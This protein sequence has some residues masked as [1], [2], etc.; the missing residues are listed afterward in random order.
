MAQL[1]KAIIWQKV[2]ANKDWEDLTDDEKAVFIEQATPTAE[3]IA[4]AQSVVVPEL[5]PFLDA[6]L[7]EVDIIG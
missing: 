7:R 6:T 5:R 2:P 1:G 4:L 3:E